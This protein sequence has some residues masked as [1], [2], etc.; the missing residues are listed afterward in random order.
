MHP[1]SFQDIA[2][3]Q[4]GRAQQASVAIVCNP[5]WLL[6]NRNDAPEMAQHAVNKQDK[7]RSRKS[8][9]DT[10]VFTKTQTGA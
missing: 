6:L 3:A 9:P 5:I 4:H 10:H 8:R 2:R 1:L 7:V